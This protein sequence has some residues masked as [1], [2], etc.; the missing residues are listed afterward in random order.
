[1]ANPFVGTAFDANGAQ[2][3]T[4]MTMPVSFLAG[5][6]H[7]VPTDFRGQPET[8]QAY[9]NMAPGQARLSYSGYSGQPSNQPEVAMPPPQAMQPMMPNVVP[10][11][12]SPFPENQNM[13]MLPNAYRMYQ[14]G[15]RQV[16]WS[17][18]VTVPEA[19]HGIMINAE[20]PLQENM[21][22]KFAYDD[23]TLIRNEHWRHIGSWMQRNTEKDASNNWQTHHKAPG[24]EQDA[25]N[26]WQTQQKAP[27]LTGSMV[28]YDL[29]P[30]RNIPDYHALNRWRNSDED[31]HLTNAEVKANERMKQEVL[32]DYRLKQFFDDQQAVVEDELVI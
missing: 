17:K 14:Y 4:S 11:T 21:W 15:P 24:A 16:W 27:G 12:P 22:G 1:M 26:N 8:W 2:K 18:R 5:Q 10:G 23:D 13:M 9:Q 19:N 25:S 30:K 32:D 6:G 3:T 28:A 7:K 31:L 20:Y 29:K